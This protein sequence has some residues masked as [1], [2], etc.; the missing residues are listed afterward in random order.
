MG[1]GTTGGESV[2]KTIVD[3]IDPN[4]ADIVF[5]V[6]NTHTGENI[7]ATVTQNDEQSGVNIENCMWTF[8]M[9]DKEIGL[10][11]TQYDNNF[12]S[13]PEELTINKAIPGTYYLH[14]LTIDYA[15]R[16]KETI[17][18]PLQIVQL[19]TGIIMDKTNSTI[20][21]GKT[22]QINVTVNPENASNKSITWTNSNETV[23]TVNQNGL[24][25]GKKRRSSKYNSKVE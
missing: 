12:K 25:T 17:S 5:D 10:D 8:N 23:A 18:G 2:S 16:A 3:E 22:L 19:V 6:N 14:V 9:E 15:G 7:K 20:D 24:V 1:N 21:V 4:G 11:V 13:N